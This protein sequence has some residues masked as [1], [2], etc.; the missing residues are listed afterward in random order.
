M[1]A[2]SIRRF[3]PQ[4]LIVCAVLFV[5][6]S[7]VTYDFVWDDQSFITELRSIRSVGNVGQMF[8]RLDAQ[9]AVPEEFVLFRPLRTLQYAL[10]FQLGGGEPP[11]AW[12]FH[13]NNVVWH[14]I[15]ALLL[16]AVARRL[17]T[18]LA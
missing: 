7:T 5:W 2:S 6:G 10:L 3:G 11:K 15:A 8:Y 17:L 18:R 1:G 9:S 16:F 12:L 14:T 4:L 13:L